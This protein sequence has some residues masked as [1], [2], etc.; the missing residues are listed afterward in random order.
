MIKFH[1]SSQQLKEFV[2]GSLTPAVSLLVSA[3]CDMCEQCQLRVESET[4]EL[5][6][7][8]VSEI[9]ESF[10]ESAQFG[11]MLSQ[12][13]QSPS[14]IEV[15][16]SSSSYASNLGERTVSIELDGRSFKLPR[17]LHRYVDKTGNWSSLVGKLWQAPVDLGNQ[18]VANFIFMGSGGS[19]P[20]H[21]HRGTEYTLVIDGEFSDG[22]SDYDTGDFIFMDGNKTHT[23]RSDTKEGCLVFSIVD[24]P[25]HFTSGLARLLNPFSHLFFR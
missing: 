13:T 18:G 8:L 7:E 20:E 24:Q 21:T 25:L 15:D 5:A 23:P 19:V 16:G 2:E 17:T 22:L 10:D 6:A 14:S 12:I 3:H 4:E 9:E 1:P 11:D